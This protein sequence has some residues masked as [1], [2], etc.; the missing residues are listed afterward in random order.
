MPSCR[1]LAGPTMVWVGSRYR[2]RPRCLSRVITAAEFESQNLRQP[3]GQA[4]CWSALHAA[5]RRGA[6][7][8]RR[9]FSCGVS[10]SCV[11]LQSVD[12]CSVRGAE[13]RP[14]AGCREM[15]SRIR[16]LAQKHAGISACFNLHDRA[17]NPRQ[18]ARSMAR[19]V[20]CGSEPAREGVVSVDNSFADPP[21]SRA[22]SLPH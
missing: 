2:S 21:L 17:P 13:I 5:A 12:E 14:T 9:P 6:P 8:G 4:P 1:A 22:G 15:P 16:S 18:F 11:P 3:A 19:R 7:N 10:G 20:Q